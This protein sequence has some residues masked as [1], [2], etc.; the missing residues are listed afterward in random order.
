MSP[1]MLR[2]SFACL[3][4]LAVL[5]VAPGIALAQS[6]VGNQYCDPLAP[7]GDQNSCHHQIG[8]AGGSGN[9]SQ[10]GSGA[11]SGS[12]S[13]GGN[14]TNG[15]NTAHLSAAARAALR[16]GRPLPA[17]GLPV[18]AILGFGVSLLA[19]GLAVRQLAHDSTG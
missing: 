13:S 8:K 14:G 1:S 7:P 10:G 15:V 3:A 11:R 18:L 9:G 6:A 2:S 19:T 4:A 16:E 5:L 17:T 12:G